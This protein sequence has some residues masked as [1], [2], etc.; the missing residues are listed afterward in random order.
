MSA[1]NCIAICKF[2]QGWKVAHCQAIK[3]IYW[4]REKGKW[5]KKDKVN[6]KILYEYFKEAKV[7]KTKARAMLEA[8]RLY[9]KIGF[10]EYGII[11]IE[12]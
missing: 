8:L 6:P 10:V 1:D 4:W 11:E 12:R 5:V 3:N 2:R 7:Y 9:N